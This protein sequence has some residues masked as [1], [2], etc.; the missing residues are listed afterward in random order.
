VD[1]SALVVALAVVIMVGWVLIQ[2]LVRPVRGGSA[3]PREISSL[4]A[5]VDQVVDMMRELDFDHALEKISG[6]EYLPRRAEL[7]ARGTELLKELDRQRR[8]VAQLQSQQEESLERE[9]A[10]RR[11]AP[12]FPPMGSDRRAEDETRTR[13]ETGQAAK[14]ESGSRRAGLCPRCGQ[15]VQVGDRFCPHCGLALNHGV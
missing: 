6:E 2:P 10:A 3:A 11:H 15:A 4:E 9:I 13:R 12:V 14:K 5:Q 7:L 8:L 1:P